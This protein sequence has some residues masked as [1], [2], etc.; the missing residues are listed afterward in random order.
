[1]FSLLIPLMEA[2][3]SLVFTVITCLSSGGKTQKSER[4]LY[5]WILWSFWISFLSALSFQQFIN[6]SSSVLTPALFPRLFQ[7]TPMRPN[8][9]YLPACLFTVLEEQFFL[10][11]HFYCGSKR[12]CWLF[13]LF[14]ILFV[15]RT[16]WQFPGSL[17][18]GLETLSWLLICGSSWI[19]QQCMW[20]GKEK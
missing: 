20:R 17:L 14:S 11:P 1:M 18:V 13:S 15:V 5:G 3:F 19:S 2:D 8:F 9:L 16:Q 6:Y 10:C 7:A 12:S 4:A